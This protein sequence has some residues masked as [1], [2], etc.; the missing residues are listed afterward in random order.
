VTDGVITIPSRTYKGFVITQSSINAEEVTDPSGP[1]TPCPFSS[2]LRHNFASHLASNGVSRQVVRKLLGHTQTASTMRY[3]HLQDAPRCAMRKI[4][5]GG[6]HDP[7][8]FPLNQMPASRISSYV[9]NRSV[10]I[11]VHLRTQ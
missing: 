5:S 11:V 6:R 9:S 8:E 7:T 10:A 1:L 2:D 4:S 3:A